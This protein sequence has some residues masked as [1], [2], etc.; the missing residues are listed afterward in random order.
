MKLFRNPLKRANQ[1]SSASTVRPAVIMP[2]KYIKQNN[3]A[4][5]TPEY[6]AARAGINR[7]MPVYSADH[8]AG[9]MNAGKALPVVTNIDDLA[10]LNQV[11]VDS[12]YGDVPFSE[13]TNE[14]I[15]ILQDQEVS[16]EVGLAPDAIIDGLGE[17]FN[18]YEVPIGL[19]NKLLLLQ[20]Y[21]ELQFIMDDSGSMYQTSDTVDE[22]GRS[23]SRWGESKNRLK[24]L[25]EILAYI[26]TP[27]ITIR[28]LYRKDRLEIPRDG[29]TP[30]QFLEQANKIIDK[31]FSKG[32][33]GPNPI[34]ECLS[35]SFSEGSDKRISR[36]I[37]CDG[38]ADY[39]DRENNELNNMVKDRVNPE[40]NPIVLLSCTESDYE[41]EGMK[42][43]E[44]I[45]PYCAEY[46]DYK[47]ESAEV[48][49]DQGAALPYTYGMHLVGQLVGAMCPEDLDAMDESVPFTKF[50]LDNLLGVVSSDAEYR[51]YFDEF[52]LAQQKRPEKTDS[53][54]LK[55]NQNWEVDYHQFLHGKLA[56]DIQSVKAFRAQLKA[57]KSSAVKGSVGNT[58]F[59]KL[60]A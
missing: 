32:P 57:G 33:R 51:H 18:K 12:G 14:S 52:K 20:T 58:F 48:L 40:G 23:Q 21:D 3:V 11:S 24:T 19:M 25:M 60:F 47:S 43:L 16:Q 1:V 59:G 4:H 34:L 42:E 53:D 50:T 55:K 6:Q 17:I 36:Y 10:A 22:R 41:C 2:P 54:K 15:D 31:A 37:F 13:A 29:K 7:H 28:F 46:D 26:P 9:S 49:K 35:D 44:E 30:E 38:F 45:A 5:V 8:R 39:N 27:E 56:G